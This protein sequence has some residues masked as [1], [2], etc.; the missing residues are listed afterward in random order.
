VTVSTICNVSNLVKND[1]LFLNDLMLLLIWGILQYKWDTKKVNGSETCPCICRRW[2]FA[3]EQ[4]WHA[5]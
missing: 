2:I 1:D 5:V 4:Q 3:V